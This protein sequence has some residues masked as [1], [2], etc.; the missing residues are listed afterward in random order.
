MTREASDAAYDCWYK[1]RILGISASMVC[2]APVDW[3]TDVVHLMDKA[4]ADGQ[5]KA[6]EEHDKKK[7]T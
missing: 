6:K 4:Y 7:G 5:K 2:D 3:D 1:T